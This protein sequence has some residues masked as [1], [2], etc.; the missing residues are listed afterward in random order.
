MGYT[1]IS[2]PV[3]SSRV[4]QRHKKMLIL[5]LKWMQA[6]FDKYIKTTEEVPWFYNERAVLGFFISGL[7]RRSNAVVLQ[8]FSCQK[9]KNQGKK[10]SSG[11]ADLYFTF[12]DVKYLVESKLCYS[13]VKTDSDIVEAEKWTKRALRQA[14]GYRKDAEVEKENVFALCFE[15][16]YCAENNFEEY[17]EKIKE[18][19]IKEVNMLGELDYYKLIEVTQAVDKQSYCWNKYFYPA[20]AVYGVFNR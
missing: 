3:I 13:P 9:G 14:N 6:E 16:I 15:V 7:V 20:L 11:R 1:K 10:N 19:Q 12:E 8:E 5:S 4:E 2:K 18:W 17:A